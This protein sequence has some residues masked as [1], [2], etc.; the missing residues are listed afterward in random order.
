MS[1]NY[2]L[3]EVAKYW[4]K[5]NDLLVAFEDFN[6]QIQK[7]M[8]HLPKEADCLYFPAP[9]AEN[10]ASLHIPATSACISDPCR[11]SP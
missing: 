10:E 9:S 8:V 2:M 11:A 6:G 3:N 5:T 4:K 7:H 1:D